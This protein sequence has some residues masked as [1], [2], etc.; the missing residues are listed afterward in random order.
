[1][2]TNERIKNAVKNGVSAKSI[3]SAAEVSY[4][5]LKSIIN[6][7]SYGGESSFDRFEEARINEALDQ[8]K[9][10]L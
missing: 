6:P 7:E 2:N 4:F 8:L 10:S 1:M 5:R 3:A 9:N